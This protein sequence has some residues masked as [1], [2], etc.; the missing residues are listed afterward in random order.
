MSTLRAVITPSQFHELAEAIG[1]I[2]FEE[3]DL[4]PHYSGRAMYGDSCIAYVGYNPAAFVVEL[5]AM[6]GDADDLCEVRE[7]MA[8]LGVPR[9]DSMGY[10]M[11]YYFP[12]VTVDGD[13]FEE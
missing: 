1:R 7:R 4:R 11:V 3:H 6:I 5:A 9:S 2:D 13:P 12:G 8:E 10:S